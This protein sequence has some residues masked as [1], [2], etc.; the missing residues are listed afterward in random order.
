M[1]FVETSI[2]LL[3]KKHFKITGPRLAVLRELSKE[4]T[5]LSAYSIEERISKN[6]P[7]SIVTVYRVLDLFERLGIVHRIHTMDGFV[8]CNFELESG[9]HYFVICSQCGKTDEF[10]E[11]NCIIEKIVPKKLSYKNL[12]HLS[13]I[14]GIC[15]SCNLSSKS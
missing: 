9:C 6:S 7:L 13:E 3:K 1:S 4:Q 11:E 10:V 15:N 5:P 2:G 12:K 14:Y 8:R